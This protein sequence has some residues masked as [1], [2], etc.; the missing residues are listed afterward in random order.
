MTTRLQR[1]FGI[2]GLQRD[3]FLLDALLLPVSQSQNLIWCTVW[4][5]HVLR[6]RY[7]KGRRFGL[8]QIRTHGLVI[9]IKFRVMHFTLSLL[10]KTRKNLTGSPWGL[11]MTPNLCHSLQ[12]HSEFYLPIR[13]GPLVWVVNE[14]PLLRMHIFILYSD[15]SLFC[16][17]LFGNG[18]YHGG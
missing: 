6:R 15:S 3:M 11:L 12:M 4:L 8:H 9:F 17:D 2:H 18:I 14:R 16:L 10:D 1:Q 7:L 13:I 5:N